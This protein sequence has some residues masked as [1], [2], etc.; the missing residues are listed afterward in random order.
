MAKGLQAVQSGGRL[1]S[2]MEDVAAMRSNRGQHGWQTE[3][4]GPARGA[5]WKDDKVEQEKKRREEDGRKKADD[6][7]M[8]RQK[9]LDLL[10]GVVGEVLEQKLKER[11]G[12]QQ[13]PAQDAADADMG[14]LTA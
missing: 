8:M 5:T 12:G 14:H 1:L 3:L 13:E 2:M 11:N 9:P 4:R 10:G 7:A 6:E